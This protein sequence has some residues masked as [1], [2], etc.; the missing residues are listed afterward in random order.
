MLNSKTLYGKKVEN[1]KMR[2][3]ENDPRVIRTRQLIQDAFNSLNKEKNFKDITIRDI[4]ERATINRTTF[5]AHFDD[6]YALMEYSVSDTFMTVVCQQLRCQDELTPETMRNLIISVCDYHEH[7]SSCKRTA[8]SILVLIEIK[9]KEQLEEIVSN[10][11]VKRVIVTET[12]TKKDVQ[13][14]AVMVSHS[15]YSAAHIWNA[16]GRKISSTALADKILC[17]LMAGLQA[18]ME[19]E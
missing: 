6:K 1:M 14:A 7:L 11:L 12:K 18:L 8:E 10:W 4:T 5:Y 16:Q 17:F 2:I 15:I 9:V 3:K 19:K 13:L